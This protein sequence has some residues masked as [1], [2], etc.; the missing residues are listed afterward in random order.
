M[1][2][3]FS[4]AAVAILWWFGASICS[5][6]PLGAP[7]TVISSTGAGSPPMFASSAGS[8]AYR[9]AATRLALM[10]NQWAPTSG[11]LFS[12][13]RI[14][15]ATPAFQIFKIRVHF[16]NWN[17]NIG[18][19]T[20][21]EVNNV[22]AQTILGAALECGGIFQSLTFSSSAGVTLTSTGEA[23]GGGIWSDAVNVTILPN[24]QCYVRTADQ[25][26]AAATRVGGYVVQPINGEGVMYSA[27]SLASLLTQG[28]VV[29]ANPGTPGQ[30]F[31]TFG[32]DGIVA[33]GT[34]GR[35]VPL[36]VGDSIL[37][38]GGSAYPDVRGNLGYL[39]RAMDDAASSTRMPYGNFGVSGSLYTTQSPMSTNWVNRLA[40]FNAL[41]NKPFTSIVSALGIN[42]IRNGLEAWPSPLQ[43]NMQAWWSDLNTNFSGFNLVQTTMGP[44]VS[45]P[46][47]TVGGQTVAAQNASPS[48]ALFSANAYIRTTPTP[49]LSGFI[50][51]IP[52]LADATSVDHWAVSGWSAKL[53]RDWTTSQNYYLTVTP[54]FG[55]DLATG[56][57]TRIPSPQSYDPANLGFV[58]V[59]TP[60]QGLIAAGTAVLEEPTS[61]GLHPGYA[62]AT[63]AMAPIVAAKNA[64]TIH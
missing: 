53:A 2:V 39:A 25:V 16:S 32:P 64:G 11:Q 35:A 10:T 50:D 17:V 5:A 52:A 60:P 3:V 31:T 34:D 54:N 21:N 26:A 56:A 6:S 22:N 61:D 29:G 19:T 8:G 15:F 55:A 51:V 38:G 43:T 18:G 24:S 48:G 30:A 20:P 57:E 4:R 23:T 33:L 13:S 28:Q 59:N 41:P 44:V 58:Q 36:L 45:C 63:A 14:Q 9:F 37:T 12:V 49:F 27:S 62:A 40:M 47:T 46:C 7:G 42:D 1:R